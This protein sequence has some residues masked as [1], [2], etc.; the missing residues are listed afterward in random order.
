MYRCFVAILLCGIAAS[1]CSPATTQV[2]NAPMNDAPTDHAAMGHGE[3]EHEGMEDGEMD[4]GAMGHAGMPA[5]QM[6]HEM[7]TEP[8]GG[9]W[10]VA[11]M[12]QAFPVVS[13]A[14]PFDSDNPLNETEP[15][16]TQ[17]AIMADLIG[18]DE[19]IVFRTT[20]NF[21]GIT[22]EDGELTYGGWGEGYIDKRHPH[23]LLHEAMLSLNFW[24]LGGGSASISAGKGFAP[25]GTDDPM[26][27]PGLKYP[28]NHH[29]SQILERW[30]VSGAYLH[31]GWGVEAGVFGGAEPEGPYDLSNIESFGDS[32]SVRLS[33]RFGAMGMPMS[34][35]WELSAS[36]A[37]VKE[38]HGGEAAATR[39]MNV[40]A[41]HE[42]EYGVG[43]LYALVEASRSGPEE[44][45]GYFSILGE[46]LL[47]RGSHQPYYRVEYATRPEFHREGAAGTDE[48]FRYDH[49]AHADGATRW[50][51]NT[52]GYGYELSGY[53]FSARPFLEL[54]HFA[55]QEGRG[56][57]DPEV[58]FGS[59][60]FWGLSAGFRIFVGGDPMRMGNYGI[61]D[62]M[63]RME[64]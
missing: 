57:V 7:W 51:I 25:Y 16:L 47:E 10:S 13:F 61:F 18:P 41:R 17:P 11:A 55:V 21:E 54:Q 42:K 29:L 31:S 27:R 23:T 9:G 44:G 52:L 38:S 33:R 19:R 6:E 46:T 49:D 56:G 2:S 63:M 4:H 43:D 48:F 15:Y 62:P 20:L 24:E 14:M 45:D 50:L 53:P 36:Y 35:P 28:T 30:L 64:H 32:W 22:L 1:A 26:S 8:L 5:D 3:P 60:S 37:R 40:A 59:N 34:A 12:A 39:L 58:L